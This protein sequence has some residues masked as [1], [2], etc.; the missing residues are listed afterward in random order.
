MVLEVSV[1]ENDLNRIVNGVVEGLG[2]DKGSEQFRNLGKVVREKLFQMYDIPVDRVLLSYGE[3]PDPPII[4]NTGKTILAEVIKRK[5][6]SQGIEAVNFHDVLWDD[7][8]GSNAEVFVVLGL[9]SSSQCKS[10][11]KQTY[12][13]APASFDYVRN[14]IAAVVENTPDSEL[15]SLLSRCGFDDFYSVLTDS[16]PRLKHLIFNCKPSEVESHKLSIGDVNITLRA[17][18]EDQILPFKFRRFDLSE[19]EDTLLRDSDLRKELLE[20]SGLVGKLGKGLYVLFRQNDPTPSDLGYRRFFAR[21]TG[22]VMEIINPSSK[23][24]VF[25]REYDE[26]VSDPRFYRAGLDASSRAALAYAMTANGVCITGG[27]STYN[28][29]VAVE[30]VKSGFP[31]PV[32][33]YLANEHFV[34]VGGCSLANFMGRRE[35][36]KELVGNFDRI[37]NTQSEEFA[38]LVGGIK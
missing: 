18:L 1:Y 20:T 35:Q 17:R 8:F 12:T 11:G 34:N 36:I 24:V 7:N 38:R 10:L 29:I 28:E 2:C 26:L 16:D 31:K 15:R 33:T 30:L 5:L 9:L 23:E 21:F 13:K 19:F 37:N 3:Q 27:G 22:E 6:K 4:K 25:R 32:L 14:S